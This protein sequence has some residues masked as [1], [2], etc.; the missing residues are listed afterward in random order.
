[1]QSGLAF[2]H[3][4]APRGALAATAFLSPVTA[5]ADG[6]KPM[7]IAPPTIGFGPLSRYAHPAS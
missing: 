7:R 1:M 2:R 4:R 5:S 6:G 3:P